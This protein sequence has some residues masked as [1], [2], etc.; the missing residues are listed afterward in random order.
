MIR[1]PAA[2]HQA[3]RIEGASQISCFPQKPNKEFLPT[4]L[5]T[6]L[7]TVP[8]LPFGILPARRQQRGQFPRKSPLFPAAQ[9][10][11][12]LDM[13]G[14]AAQSYSFA[15]RCFEYHH[16]PGGIELEPADALTQ[17]QFHGEPVGLKQN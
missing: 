15:A 7:S 6:R 9:E 5:P 11:S 16:G 8:C 12:D 17:G 2:M 14:R 3:S 13:H 10:S 1:S 4:R